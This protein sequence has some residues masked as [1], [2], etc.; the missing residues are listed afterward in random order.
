MP[1]T[2]AV[3]HVVMGIAGTLMVAILY[4]RVRA[5][6]RMR[7]GLPVDRDLLDP[8]FSLLAMG[9]FGVPAILCAIYLHN[10]G[11][12]TTGLPTTAGATVIG[13]YLGYLRANSHS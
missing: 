4:A 5:T 12:D 7:K 11:F 2:I 1:W 9:F 6:D 13:L 10:Q 8:G 3:V